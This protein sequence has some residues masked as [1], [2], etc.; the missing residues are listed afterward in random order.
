MQAGQCVYCKRSFEKIEVSKSDIIPDFFG[1]GLI[2]ENAVCK[3]CNNTFNTQVENP[4]RHHFQ[5][6]RRELY[7]EGRRGRPVKVDT[8]VEIDEVG[9]TVGTELDHFIEKG[10][11][12]FT[13]T[14]EDGKEYYSVIG[15]NE[16]VEE[17][18]DMLNQK[19]PNIEW[20]EREEFGVRTTFVA[21]PYEVMYSEKGKRLAAKIAFERLC[22]KL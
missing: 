15:N 21:L 11:R 2:L 14:G 18:K 6:L 13:F 10:V 19:K 5:Y 12:P 7:L 17:M 1:N 22:Q 8:E 3:D 16:Y 4:L 9:K 20:K